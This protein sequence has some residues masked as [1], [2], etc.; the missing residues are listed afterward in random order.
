MSDISK[1]QH[2]LARQQ[3]KKCLVLGLFL[4]YFVF[5]VL[6]VTYKKQEKIQNQGGFAFLIPG[7][8]AH[9]Q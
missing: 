8:I 5:F 4:I 2:T 6:H 3:T 9:V 7:S 1:G